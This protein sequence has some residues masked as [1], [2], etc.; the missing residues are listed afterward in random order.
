M[1][2][3]QL[4]NPSSIVVVGGSNN[5]HKPG[6]KLL[7]NIID[8]GYTGELYVVNPK[9]DEVQGVKSYRF[10]NHIPETE[11]AF[12][13]IPAQF[14]PESVDF[15]ARE[16]NTRAFVI[17]SAGFSEESEEGRQ[18]EEEIVDIVNKYD[19]CLIG[20]NCIGV[21]NTTYSG[22]FTTPVPRLDPGGCD[23]ISASGATAVFIM[24]SGI[25]KGLT[26]SAVYSVGNSAQTGVEDILEYMDE[27]FDPG[28]SSRVKLLYIEKIDNPD[29]LLKHSSS[30]VRKGCRIAA[31]KSGGSEAGS[32]AA[33]S[34]TGALASSDLAVDALFRKAGIIRCYGR[35]ELITVA[36]VLMHPEIKG[37]NIAIVTHAGGPAV[38]LTDA[39]SHGGLKIPRLGGAPAE[40]LLGQL[41]EG[42]S[43]SNP[44]D[45]LATG[46]ARQLAVVI[47]YCEKKFEN[48]DAIMVI[49][50]STGLTEVFD[51]YEVLHEKMKNSSIPIFPILPSL[52]TARKELDFFLS[53]G[54]V[55]FPD[56]VLLGRAVAKVYNTPFP[57]EEKIEEEGV[58]IKAVRR[59]IDKAKTGYAD[60]DT[61]RALLDAASIITVDEAFVKSPVKLTEIAEKIG[62]PLAMKV[63][64]PVHKSD[65]NGVVL[66]VNT[67]KHLIAEY[68]R[69]M[70]ID[71]AEGVLLQSM[72]SGIELFLGA[73]YEPAFGHVILCGLG[74]IFVEVLKDVSSGLAPL[75]YPEA[76]S[77]LRS[78]KSYKI[79]KGARGKKGVN[80]DI[81]A[82][83][84]VRLSTMLRYATEIKEMDLNPLIGTGDTIRVVDAR[85][86]IEK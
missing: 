6:G 47:D 39:L 45:L 68:A 56:E 67:E 48:V 16:K 31:I 26:F 14:C 75:T 42:A 40:E 10:I 63:I 7:R 12:L 66:N 2:N 23:F 43:V 20:P 4:L 69:L 83:I 19:A 27:H 8:N 52:N 21:I 84:M 18:L 57:A 80:E 9:E 59:I 46:T 49:F 50:G 61:I 81:L 60:P 85:I 15:L 32:R 58:D 51:A 55:N 37:E 53:Q 24:E 17:I 62:Y 44:I 86:K 71:G 36:S 11:L 30:L 22:V 41:N 34:H 25:P 3:R 54:H 35:E 5:V 77:M 65:V 70:E 1:I 74:G 38:M 29:K 82:G 28:K 33:S 72:I 13:V 79:I 76:Y 73:K 64:G 78:I